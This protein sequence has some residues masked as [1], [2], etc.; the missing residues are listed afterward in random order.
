MTTKNYNFLQLLQ[1]KG[2]TQVSLCHQCKSISEP[3]LSRIINGYSLPKDSTLQE[4]SRI[5]NTPIK[6]ISK[7]LNMK[8]KE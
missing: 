7:I 3:M 8:N 6:D 2:F 4:L 1:R 5:L